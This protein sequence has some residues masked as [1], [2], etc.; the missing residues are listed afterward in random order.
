MDPLSGCGNYNGS[1]E[2]TQQDHHLHLPVWTLMPQD[3]QVMKLISGATMPKM[4]LGIVMH[5]LV[6]VAGPVDGILEAN[7][8]GVIGAGQ[9]INLY[10]HS[11][12]TR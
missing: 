4:A 12:G 8:I 7:G 5:A 6:M 11:L 2:M 1:Q 9:H 10:H 3:I